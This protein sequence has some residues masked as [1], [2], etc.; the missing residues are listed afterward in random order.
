MTG[1]Q[2]EIAAKIIAKEADYV[3]ALKSVATRMGLPEQYVAG[4]GS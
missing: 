4:I 2:T 1:C 3:L